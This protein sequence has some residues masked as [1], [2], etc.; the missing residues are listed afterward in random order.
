M[1]FSTSLVAV[2]LTALLST[3]HAGIALRSQLAGVARSIATELQARRTTT[4]RFGP[5]SGP[6]SMTTSGAGLCQMLAHELKQHNVLVAPDASIV[7][8]GEYSGLKS[9]RGLAL[10]VKFSIAD[11]NGDILRQ[12]DSAVVPE[13]PIRNGI[14]TAT[15]DDERTAVSILQPTARIYSDLPALH[16]ANLVLNSL[17][18]NEGP[19]VIRNDVV[20]SAGSSPYGV[21]ILVNGQSRRPVLEGGRA[22]VDIQRNE[23]YEIQLT[24]HSPHQS[25]AVV[26]IDGIN[27]FAFSDV[28]AT[29]GPRKGLPAYDT[30]ILKPRS[31]TTI[32]GWH[33]DNSGKNNFHA[34]RVTE[35]AQTGAARLGQTANVGT[36]TVAFSAAWESGTPPPAYLKEPPA[37]R[38][39]PDGTGF[40]LPKS[41]TV[42]PVKV[43]VGVV[44]SV[45]SIRY[46]RPD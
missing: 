25:A 27:S 22:F 9:D 14:V 6:S 10:R 45:V 3:V 20:S 39:L 40:G 44:R 5:F 19:P 34:F 18:G 29:S 8:R 17:E 13:F 12:F 30:W 4:V 41:L 35:Y 2:L 36:I 28:R 23:Q 33:R 1:R 24:N 16:R 38:G 7:I 26:A 42:R 46:A 37:T 32:P 11:T 21:S 15:V 31:Q 43:E